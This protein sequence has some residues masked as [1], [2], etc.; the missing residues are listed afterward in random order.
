M[1]FVSQSNFH[2][3][4]TIRINEPPEVEVHIVRAGRRREEPESPV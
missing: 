1:R 3:D 2:D 4:R